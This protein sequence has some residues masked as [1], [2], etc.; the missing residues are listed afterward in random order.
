MTPYGR[1]SKGPIFPF[2]DRCFDARANGVTGAV[3]PFFRSSILKNHG[4]VEDQR[5]KLLSTEIRSHWQARSIGRSKEQIFSAYFSPSFPSAGRIRRTRDEGAVP[6][7]I[8]LK[9]S[10]KNSR[11]GIR[12]SEIRGRNLSSFNYQRKIAP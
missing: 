10:V 1:F 9:Y 3:V 8:T 7:A 2:D 12:R 5:R 4:F 6:C 11:F